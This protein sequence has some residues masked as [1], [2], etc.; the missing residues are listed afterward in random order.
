MKTRSCPRQIQIPLMVLL[1]SSP[2]IQALANAPFL[3]VSNRWY[4][5]LIKL[6]D[7][8]TWTNRK[9]IY[10]NDKIFIKILSGHKNIITHLSQFIVV[11]V[12]AK[13]NAII[14]WVK[15][16]PEVR[17]RLRLILVGVITFKVVEVERTFRHRSERI[18]FFRLSCQSLF[19]CIS[20]VF[21]RWSLFRGNLGL[22]L[23]FLG[24]FWLLLGFFLLLFFF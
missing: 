24:F 23:R 17:D 15:L 8:K 4:I 2:N 6:H 18:L 20:F 9:H 13:P 5:P 11:F 7:M 21:Y 3:N 12:F 10:V 1:L 14:L 16:L 22:L 19:R